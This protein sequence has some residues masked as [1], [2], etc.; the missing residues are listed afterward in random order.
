[1]TPGLD[2]FTDDDADDDADREDDGG[3]VEGGGVD[4]DAGA[5]EVETVRDRVADALGDRDLHTLTVTR[6]DASG[7]GPTA[8]AVALSSTTMRHVDDAPDHD[9]PVVDARTVVVDADGPLGGDD[10]PT[11]SVTLTENGLWVPRDAG[12]GESLAQAWARASA[13]LRAT[14]SGP[15]LDGDPFDGEPAES[16]AVDDWG[17]GTLLDAEVEAA[18]V[19]EGQHR[20]KMERHEGVDPSREWGYG[21]GPPPE[22]ETVADRLDAVDLD[23]EDHLSRLVWGKKE[24]MDRVTRPVSELTGNYGI[25]VLPRDDGLVAVDVDDPDELPAEVEAALPE[26]LEVSSPHGDDRRRHI[27]LRC[28][29]KEAVADAVGGWAVQG[30]TWG[31]LWI[32]DR[33]VVG[34]GS[35]L[36][37]Y[38]CDDGDHTRGEAGGCEACS[39][40]DAGFYRIVHDA[41]IGEV[42]AETVVDLLR[43]SEGFEVRDAPSTPAAPEDVDGDLDAVA[44]GEAGAVETGGDG[45]RGDGDGGE[46]AA[47]VDDP[48]LR[49]DNCG[50]EVAE[51]ESDDLKT[52][53]L[54]GEVR[55]ICRGGCE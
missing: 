17:A 33:Y 32:G 1:M 42:E 4:G 48:T 26:T 8:Y 21:A 5:V 28:R 11:V 39:D 7:D 16:S 53:T 25:E 30:A 51:A 35:Q 37:A 27:L 24:P 12:V 23:P 31:D 50:R 29:D 44:G 9:V 2:A 3:A 38:G 6:V 10:P 41:P 54:R 46:G 19:P 45:D 15:D 36:S 40:P 49:C 43:A 20:D 13:D 22:V 14:V 52:V 55:R 34:P 18:G 47:G